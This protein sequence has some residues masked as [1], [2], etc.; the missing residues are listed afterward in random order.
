MIRSGDY[1]IEKGF[2][3]IVIMLSQL[4]EMEIVIDYYRKSV[5]VVEEIQRKLEAASTDTSVTEEASKHL[6]TFQ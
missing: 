5:G 6:P 4:K 2:M 1:P 3:D